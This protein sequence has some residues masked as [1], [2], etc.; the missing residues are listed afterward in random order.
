MAA[1]A[2]TEKWFTYPSVPETIP[3]GRQRANYMVM[4]FWD[5]C[6]WKNAYSSVS[7]MESAL[8]D[9][10]EL[11]PHASADTV[12][13]SINK[14]IKE[15]S[16]RPADMSSLLRMARATF[17]SDSAALFSDEVYM[18]F[19][20]AGAS[21]K[22]LPAAERERCARELEVLRTCSEG[23]T[24]PSITA[25]GRDGSTFALNDTI[26]GA[27][28]YVIILENPDNTPAR[29]DRV[30][31]ASNISAEALIDAGLLKPILI[32]AGTPGEAW[33]ASTSS[34]S[35]KWAVGVMPDADR[36][37]DLRLSPAVYVL[38]SSMQIERKLMPLNLLIAN[39]EQLLRNLR[40]SQQ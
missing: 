38:N 32:A 8:R 22:K 25:T 2:Q 18:P 40:A 6:P 15:T 24:L 3:P 11:L 23:Q 34:L 33:W 14:L 20:A 39:C 17:Q 19:A 28:T 7:R 10:A 35:D 37:F 9:F 12:H 31:F 16:K 29:F 21:A 5:R 13:L 30:R 4:H 27:A 36:H 1:A 26:S